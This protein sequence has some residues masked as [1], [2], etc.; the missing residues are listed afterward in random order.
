MPDINHDQEQQESKTIIS[1]E[2]E[3][4][5][6]KQCLIAC[7]ENLNLLLQSFQEIIA[8]CNKSK[9]REENLYT[10]ENIISTGFFP[11]LLL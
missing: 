1:E 4:E 5:N 6:R 8:F 9:F 11:S 3:L 2:E 10:N 7:K